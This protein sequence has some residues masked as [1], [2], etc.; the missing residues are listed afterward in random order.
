MAG[1]AS[2]LV[3][4]PCPHLPPHRGRL[5]HR[6]LG[7]H[8]AGRGADFYLSALRYGHYLWRHGHTG[9]A[10]LALARALYAKTIAADPV[11]RRHPLPYAAIRWVVAEHGSDDF[12]GNPRIS[13]Q[14]QARRMRGTRQDL[15]RA[16]AWAAWALVRAARPGLPDDPAEDH[17]PEPSTGQIEALLRDYGH[18]GEAQLWRRTLESAPG[19]PGSYPPR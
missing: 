6:V 9:R 1:C 7:S 10:I 4:P 11:L 5:D 8:G 14:H 19:E 18:A 16:R 2:K 3:R 13:F 12:P 17:L 15:R